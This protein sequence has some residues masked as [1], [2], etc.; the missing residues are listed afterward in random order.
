M[1]SGMHLFSRN[2][3]ICSWSQCK[4]KTQIISLDYI[5]TVWIILEEETKMHLCSVPELVLWD[6]RVFP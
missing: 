3:E 2:S 5:K 1:S 6:D 4:N